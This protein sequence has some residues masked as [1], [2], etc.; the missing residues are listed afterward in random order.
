[1]QELYL[2]NQGSA[3]ANVASDAATTTPN[4]EIETAEEISPK[5]LNCEKGEIDV[6]FEKVK[7]TVPDTPSD[8][9]VNKDQLNLK[10][11]EDTLKSLANSVPS[12][13]AVPDAPTSL[14]QD[15][16]QYDLSANVENEPVQ[17]EKTMSGDVNT[18]NFMSVEDN[19]D[20]VIADE[21]VEEDA[22]VD[23]NTGKVMSSEEDL[24]IVK[25][26][27]DSKKK[28]G[29]TGVGKRL[30]E[31]KEKCLKLLLKQQSQ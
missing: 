31:R 21:V 29:K 19:V 18:D 20:H 22:N 5:S 15:Q 9:E 2:D 30:R 6:D 7:N 27:G 4:V 26:V 25:T 10:E 3:S 14:A 8:D 23:E 17:Q 28:S 11:A 16:S 12:A 13:N 24:V 1:M